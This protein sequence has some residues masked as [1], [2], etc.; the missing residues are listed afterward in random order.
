MHQDVERFVGRD[1][2]MMPVSEIK[3]MFLANQ[4]IEVYQIAE[5]AATV[6]RYGY[7]ADPAAWYLDFLGRIRL[8][9]HD[10]RRG[11]RR[12]HEKLS[13]KNARRPAAGFCR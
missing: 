7:V 6:R 11:N 9:E 3:T 12:T 8:G 10:W 2:M 4:A 13:G 1:S 5:S